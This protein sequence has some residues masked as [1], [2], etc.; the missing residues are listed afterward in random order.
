[1]T[2][3]VP[4]MRHIQIQNM[5]RIGG[6]IPQ[7]KDFHTC[8]T[9]WLFKFPFLGFGQ[10]SRGSVFLLASSFPKASRSREPCRD[11]PS[12]PD[13]ARG[14]WAQAARACP[15]RSAC[16][17]NLPRGPAVRL[18]PKSYFSKKSRTNGAPS[19]FASL[20]SSQCSR[21]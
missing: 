20:M 14:R 18:L 17:S 21:H 1:M 19:T 15:L 4:D 5:R 7:C 13:T 8:S 9:R 12:E 10:L 6:S 2:V 11:A 3:A 16:P